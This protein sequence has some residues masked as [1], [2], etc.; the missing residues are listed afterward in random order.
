MAIRRHHQKKDKEPVKGI[1]IVY[2]IHLQRPLEH[3]Q[4]YV[5]YTLDFDKRITDHLCGMGSRLLQVCMERGIQ[6]KVVRTWFGNRHFE[7]RLK[8]WK[9]SAQFCPVCKP[10]TARNRLKEPRLHERTDL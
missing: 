6:W 5:G 8:R 7:R 1:G 10:S 3:A 2:L 4:H 9:G